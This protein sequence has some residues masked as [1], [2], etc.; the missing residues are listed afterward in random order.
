MTLNEEEWLLRSLR[1]LP[2]RTTAGTFHLSPTACHL[3]GTQHES[4]EKD[5][6]HNN[7]FDVVLTLDECDQPF[8][9]VFPQLS[10][11]LIFQQVSSGLYL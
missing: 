2:L 7:L 9:R 6:Y 10:V 5:D 3:V 1:S 4:L 8:R 11:G